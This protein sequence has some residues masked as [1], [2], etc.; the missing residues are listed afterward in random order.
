MGL[1]IR[2]TRSGAVFEPVSKHLA[3]IIVLSRNNIP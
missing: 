3:T 2:R 1:E